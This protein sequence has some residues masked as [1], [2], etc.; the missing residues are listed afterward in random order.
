[1]SAS[2]WLTSIFGVLILVAGIAYGVWVL[3]RWFKPG[4]LKRP[5]GILAAVVAFLLGWILIVL[6]LLAL[7]VFRAAIRPSAPSS[8][9]VVVGNGAA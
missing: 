8:S 1:V 5:S 7:A 3:R 4:K 6:V 2:Q 9:A